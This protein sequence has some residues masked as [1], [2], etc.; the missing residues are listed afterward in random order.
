M[1]VHEKG[2]PHDEN[3]MAGTKTL[4]GTLVPSIIGH[5]PNE[6]YRFTRYIAHHG[7]TISAIV[8]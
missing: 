1:I 7:A 8:V 5:V 3:A 6:M 2:N 4:P